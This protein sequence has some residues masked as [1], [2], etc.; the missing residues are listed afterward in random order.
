[1]QV[2]DPALS[3][4]RAYENDVVKAFQEVAEINIHIQKFG[5]EWLQ[6]LKPDRP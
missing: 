2:N 1:M 6:N 3:W 4:I 5:E